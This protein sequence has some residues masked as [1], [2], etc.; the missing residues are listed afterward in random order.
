MHKK[1]AEKALSLVGQGYIYGAKGQ[2]CSPVF[3]Q[4]QA[5]QYPDQADNI[6]GTGAK[7]DGKPVWDCA[8]LTRACAKEGGVSLVS[9]ATSQWNK[10]D[11]NEYGPIETI[12]EGETVF[13][14]RQ[15]NENGTVMQ[16]TGVA[17]GDGTCVHARGTAYGVVRQQLDEYPWTH[18][19]RPDWPEEKEEDTMAATATVTAPTGTVNMR[20]SPTRSANLID[21]LPI[22]TVVEVTAEVKAGDGEPWRQIRYNGR[23]GW[24]MAQYLVLQG[25]AETPQET[26]QDGQEG[27]DEVTVTLP[28]SVALALLEA[29]KKAVDG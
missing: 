19:A 11:W 28:R 13:L 9:G 25:G 18:W 16:H 10:T 29:L 5:A 7:W 24:M 12:P 14:Y 27:K 26:P 8:Q 22:G 17:L 15:Q 2:T 21:R 20:V 6:L 4:Q 23:D 1:V 3:R